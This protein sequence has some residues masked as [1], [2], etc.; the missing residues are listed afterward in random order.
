[1]EVILIIAVGLMNIICLFFGVWIGQK[2]TK[3]ERVEI[4]SSLEALNPVKLYRESQ[5]KRAARK[6]QEKLNTI[7]D[8][9]ENYNGTSIG[10]KDVR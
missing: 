10:Q 6:E 5:E 3:G 4:K 9:I 8:N 1:M 7:L 2:T